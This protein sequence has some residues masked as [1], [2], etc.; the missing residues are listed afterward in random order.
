MQLHFFEKLCSDI[1]KKIELNAEKIFINSLITTGGLTKILKF[2][3]V[4][5]QTL[6]SVYL[7]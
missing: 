7:K 6:K 3:L 5:A 1:L 2:R 4:S